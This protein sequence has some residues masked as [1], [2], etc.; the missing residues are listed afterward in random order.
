MG[1]KGGEKMREERYPALRALSAVLKVLAVLVF[2]AGL[3]TGVAQMLQGRQLGAVSYIVGLGIIWAVL[4]WAGAEL[5]LV[6]LDI[7]RN[8]RRMAELLLKRPEKEQGEG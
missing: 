7:E 6:A 5:I 1:T 8:T 2:L 4:L 3:A